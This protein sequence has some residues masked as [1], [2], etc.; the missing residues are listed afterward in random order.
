MPPSRRRSRA[1][2]SASRATARHADV[3]RFARA[4]R[5]RA[6]N[7]VR[8]GSMGLSAEGRDL[9]VAVLSGRGAFTP[10]AARRAGLPIVMVIA[11]I[12]AGEVEGKEALQ[13]LARELTLGEL[14]PLLDQLTLVLVPDYNADGNDRI[15]P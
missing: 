14:R 11:N 8:L 12:H 1:R 6:P 3:L 7:L 9:V 10:A 2:R 15:S 4:V 13:A 5:R